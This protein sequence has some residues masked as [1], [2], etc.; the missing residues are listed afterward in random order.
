MCSTVALAQTVNERT[1]SALPVKIVVDASGKSELLLSPIAPIRVG[2]ALRVIP[3]RV[4]VWTVDAVGNSV[5]GA[6]YR[7]RTERTDRAFRQRYPGRVVLRPDGS[8]VIDEL[9]VS[10]IDGEVR[11][12]E[13]GS[14]PGTK[15]VEV[16]ASRDAEGEYLLPIFPRYSQRSPSISYTYVTANEPSGTNRSDLERALNRAINTY[17][18]LLANESFTINFLFAWSTSL[19]SGVL[20][21]AITTAR[22]DRAFSGFRNNLQAIT[23]SDV[24]SGEQALVDNLPPNTTIP[25]SRSGDSNTSTS[26]ICLCVPILA[27][28]YGVTSPAT[29]VVQLNP[30]LTW[31]FDGTSG[32]PPISSGAYDFEAV[33]A[34]E[35]GHHFGFLSET[36]A[37]GFFYNYLSNWDIFRFK[38]SDGP[39]IDSGEMLGSLRE[40]TVGTSALGATALQTTSRTYALSNGSDHQSSHWGDYAV[41][42]SSY[43]GIMNPTFDLGTSYIKNGSYLQNADVAAFDVMGYDIEASSILSPPGPANPTTPPPHRI[44]RRKGLATAWAAAS[45]AETYDV[46]VYDRGTSGTATPTI[47]YRTNDL[48]DTGTAIPAAPLAY[49]HHYDWSVVSFNWRGYVIDSSDFMVACAADYDD[50]DGMGDPDGGVAIEDLPYYLTVYGDGVDAADLDDGSDTGTPDGGVAIEDLLYF[51]ARYDDGC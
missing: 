9:I 13:V 7:N 46:I 27:K 14:I 51:L 34:H 38:S 33:I 40:L 26:R 4:P 16:V 35:L 37:V 43:I 44:V 30:A 24:D 48:T 20:A 47:V 39:D 32:V 45:N 8:W 1:I 49:N 3:R 10:V 41:S 29:M 22:D 15:A 19:G 6:L 5:T 31:D 11:P 21:Q 23:T 42:S 28:W 18:Q 25:Y 50:G 12:G 17:T 2:D 36:E